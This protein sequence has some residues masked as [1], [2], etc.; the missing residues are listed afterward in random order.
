MR[1]TTWNCNRA[2][3]KKFHFLADLGSDLAIVQECE[4][5][6]KAG[7]KYGEWAENHIWS[8]RNMNSG[9][10]IFASKEVGLR[11]LDWP[12]G[13]L[14]LFIPCVV[15]ESFILVAVWT[16][17]S[18]TTSYSYIGQLWKYIQQHKQAL[19]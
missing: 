8:G 2:F 9:L 18:K 4:S 13:A 14:E 15:N 3:R 19:W 16:K 12:D 6:V 5:P 1:I 10:G 11:K 17:Q 7:G